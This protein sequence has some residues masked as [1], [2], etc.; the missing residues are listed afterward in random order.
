MLFHVRMD[1][2]IPHDLDPAERGR[3]I[4]NEKARALELPSGLAAHSP[5]EQT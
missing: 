5:G 2:A 4:A 3:L 1:V